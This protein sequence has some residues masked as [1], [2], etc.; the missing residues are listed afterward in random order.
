MSAL[1]VWKCEFAPLE[2][3]ASLDALTVGA[4][5]KLG[6]RGDIPVTWG[7]GPLTAQFPKKEAEYTLHVLASEKLGAQEAVLIVTGYKA[8]KHEPEYVRFLQKD[9]VGFET[10]KP[11]WTI[12]TVLPQD[13]P[14]EPAPPFGPWA[15]GLPYWVLGTV[16]FTF[17]LLVFLLVRHLRKRAQ[18]KRIL[19]ELERHRTVLTPANQFYKDARVLRRRMNDAKSQDEVKQLASDLNREFRLYVLRLFQ[20][21]SLE[22]SDRAIVEDVRKRH[23]QGFKEYSDDLRKTLRELRRLSAR[24]Q[25]QLADVEQLHRMSMGTVERIEAARANALRSGGRMWR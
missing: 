5:F 3:Q 20:V 18:R 14:A 2:G 10:L 12:Q 6:C 16:F 4:K 21:P 8:G 23:R 24:G 19:A 11:N 7:E 17:A 13:R 9:G 25:V 1:P 15:P 22:W